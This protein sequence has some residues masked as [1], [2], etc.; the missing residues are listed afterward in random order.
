MILDLIIILL[1]II[2]GFIGYKVGFLTTLI[3][4]TSALSGIIIAICFTKPITNMVCDLGW[5][6][7]V[8][9]QVYANVISSDVFQTYVEGGEGVNGINQLLQELGIPSFISSFIAGG[10]AESID[11]HEI[12]LKIADGVS[13]VLVFLITFVALLLFSSLFFLLLKLIVKGIRKSVGFIR[14]I[15]GIFGI[16]F[17]LLIFFIILCIVFMIISLIMQSA[18]PNGGFVSFFRDQ[19][20]LEDDT[21]GI[22]KY[23]YENNFIGNFFGLIF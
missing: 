16:I 5:D 4:L 1:V 22:A 2:I 13:Y 8:E 11:P 7:A 9:D 18:D 21:F 23:L 12:A 15:D 10:I 17:F 20:H 6:K 3:K 14:V 19:L